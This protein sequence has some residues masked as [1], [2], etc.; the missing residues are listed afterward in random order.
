MADPQEVI[1]IDESKCQGCNKCIRHCPAVGANIAYK[2]ADGISKV[3]V[4]SNR[5]F[6]CGKCLEVC[7]H[8][9]RDYR[10]DTERFFTDLKL[11][12]MITVIAAPAIRVNFEEYLRM[13]GYLK[14]LGVQSIYDVSFGADIVVWAYLKAIKENDLKSM[15]AQPCP[16]VVNYVQRYQPELMENL[17]P[18]HSPMM[19]T[20]I[21]L[22]KYQAVTNDIA[23][24]SPCIGKISEINDPNTFGYVKY[25][26]TFKKLQ[27]YLDTRRIWYADFQPTNFDDFESGL[28]FLFSRPGGLR[29]NI[30]VFL[31]NAWIR[32]IEG[33][34][35]I[36][37]Y[38]NEY[39]LRTKK[40]MSRPLIVDLLNCRYGC[41]LG[42]GTC[43]AKNIDEIDHKF[44]EMK[45]AKLKEKSAYLEKQVK[46]LFKKLD[47]Q[48]KLE[49]F[50]RGY[51]RDRDF[52]PLKELSNADYEMNFSKL[53]KNTIQSR[54]INCS[55]CGYDTCREMAKAL[56]NGINLAENCI[57]Y[58][59]YIVL[60]DNRELVKKNN[61]IKVALEEVQRLNQEN[62]TKADL[63]QQQVKEILVSIEE[64]AQGTNHTAK[65]ISQIAIEITT[66]MEGA[67]QLRLSV[68][69]M[70]EKVTS[71]TN[72]SK[73][74]VGISRQTD[75]LAINAA[76]EAARAGQ[77][78]KGFVS[79]SKEVKKLSEQSRQMA[80]A[81]QADQ[82]LMNEVMQSLLAFSDAIESKVTAVNETIGTISATI[83]EIN[84]KNE[85]VASNTMSLMKQNE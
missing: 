50:R 18:I 36:Y 46:F 44:N 3:K 57:D 77:E 7:D 27:T 85:E 23:F 9:A 12:K 72:A 10:D 81:T 62:K 8:Q 66:I 70:M 14:S 6:Q 80:E 59:R 67:N 21:Y 24:L 17:A 41:N 29:E 28:G 15:I 37:Q 68:G 22:R 16:V 56:G 47:T 31:N 52:I 42:T 60:N 51:S 49:D 63:L 33:Q 38:L 43:Q 61:E 54:E 39:Y 75:L 34:E 48:L 79:V 45:Q 73:K 64:V 53:H 69:T 78:A 5:C 4:D 84:A 83:E 35:D 20:A 32:Q 11:G 25:N 76:I 19:A 55:A 40:N 82:Q 1:F 26:V 13:F 65:D 30:E 58:N 2:A 74:I 71:F